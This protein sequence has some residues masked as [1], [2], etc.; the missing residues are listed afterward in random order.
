MVDAET[1]NMIQLVVAAIPSG[2][3]A[4]YG[5]I[6]ALVGLPRGARSV[7]RVLKFSTCESLPWHRI[8]RADG[9][10]APR[11]GATQQIDRL[12]R[13]GVIVENS[14]VSLREYRWDE[15]ELRVG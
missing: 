6:A 12:R 13:E 1:R 8:V 11:P 5:Q 10:I 14:R 7:A 2:R 9:L 15:D 4:T 3:V